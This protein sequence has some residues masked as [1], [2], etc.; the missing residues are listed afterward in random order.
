MRPLLSRIL[1]AVTVSANTL[2]AIIVLFIMFLITADTISLYLFSKPFGI[3]I[4]IAE[5]A[6]VVIVLGSFAAAQ[7]K[8]E[9]VR[10]LALYSK[11]GPR[12]QL[13]C[14]VIA[15]LIGFI[16]FAIIMVQSWGNAVASFNLREWAPG[17]LQFPI[18][19]FKF[20]VPVGSG[21]LLLQLI[22]GL[23]GRIIKRNKQE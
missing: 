23:I 14:D 11:F 9:N 4:V 1:N 20:V 8:G 6:L 19:P 15:N 22:S 12:G 3:T 21:L 10:L 5:V 16:I 13:I 18:Y 17:S 7:A 2:S